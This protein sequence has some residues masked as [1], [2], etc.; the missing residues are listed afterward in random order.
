M[1]YAR[2]Q[3]VDIRHLL[4][5]LCLPRRLDLSV[6][7]NTFSVLLHWAR[8]A[9][10]PGISST[11]GVPFCHPAELV[12]RVG[13]DMLFR[14]SPGLVAMF[15]YVCRPM[16]SFKALGVSRHQPCGVRAHAADIRIYI[17]DAF[18]TAI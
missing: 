2:A 12:G 10:A 14:V 9:P 7:G 4:R 16:T 11:V 1:T 3:L 17:A 5:L 6:N 13:R 8:D 18:H 15:R